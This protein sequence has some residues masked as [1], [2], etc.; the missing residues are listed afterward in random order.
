MSEKFRGSAVDPL[1][2]GTMLMDCK[3]ELLDPGAGEECEDE[4]I[5]EEL[6]HTVHNPFLFLSVLLRR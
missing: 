5:P 2:T 4:F 1:W 6:L 3:K